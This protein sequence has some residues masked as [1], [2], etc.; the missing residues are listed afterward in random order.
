MRMLA[1]LTFAATLMSAAAANAASL[2]FQ[3]D[4]ANSSIAVTE[5]G[6]VC[7][8]SGGCALSA[9]LLLP[10]SDLTIEEGA[11]NAQSFNF[12]NF[13]VSPGFGFDT[14][15]RVE[16]V[17]AFIN[18]QADPAGAAGTASYL[19]LGGFFTPGVV[20]GSLIWDNPVQHITAL[21]GSEFTVAFGDLHGVTFGGNAISPVTIT[22]NSVAAVP[23]PATWGMMI[24][25]FGGI[26]GLIR[27]RRS[28]VATSA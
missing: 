11:A 16:A 4:A 22:V 15:A 24:I 9:N 26:G 3:F 6:R 21:D 14:D 23:E 13:N 5:N 10:F 1:S 17:L 18:P 2:L 8:P 28:A 12:A 20:G 19:R 25:G 27:R 7:F